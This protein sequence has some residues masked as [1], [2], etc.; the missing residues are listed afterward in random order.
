MERSLMLPY[1]IFKTG[2]SNDALTCL[3]ILPNK[4][5]SIRAYLSEKRRKVRIFSIGQIISS[6][7]DD[8]DFREKFSDYEGTV[9]VDLDER[10]CDW[11]CERSKRIGGNSA[12]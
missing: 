2:L 11:E 8:F 4:H 5:S 10:F 7:I 12:K 6:S 1:R 3:P 9:A